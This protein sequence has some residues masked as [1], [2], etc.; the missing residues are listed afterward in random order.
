MKLSKLQTEIINAPY[1]KVVVLSSAASGKTNIL[2]EK[3]RQVLR[4]GVDPREIAVITFTNM[5]AGELKTRLG[6][7][8][9]EGMYIGTIHGLANFM[10]CRAGIDTSKVLDEEKFDKLFT[11]IKKNPQSVRHLE[12]ILLD[13]AQ[14]SDPDQFEFIFNMIKPDYF[15]VVGDE[16]Q[17]IYQWRGARP[18]LIRELTR[19]SDVHTFNLNENYRNKYNI[20]SYAKSIIRQTGLADNSIAMSDGGIVTKAKFSSDY[21]VSKINSIGEYKDWAILTRTNTEL[22]NIVLILKKAKIPYDTFKQGDLDKEQLTEKMEANTVKVL[23]IHSAKGL[24]WPNVMVWGMRFYNNE[25]YNVNYVAVTRAKD[26]LIILSGG[27]DY[28]KFGV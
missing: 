1:D 17:S 23:T 13:E 26:N 3:T 7:D 2:T 19:K 9:K 24:E 28:G 18:K 20:L 5:A 10:L 16:K 27:K 11:L 14:D 25:E 15:F 6:A 4:A 8:Y 21:I 12:W 22:N